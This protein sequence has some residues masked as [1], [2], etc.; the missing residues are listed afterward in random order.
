MHDP[1]PRHG[2]VDSPVALIIALSPVVTGR[3]FSDEAVHRLP[4][5]I[6]VADMPRVLLDQ[7]DRECA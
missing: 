6:G 3:I 1:W 7:V 4:D 5:E 2:R